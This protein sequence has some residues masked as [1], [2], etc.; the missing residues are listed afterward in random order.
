MIHIYDTPDDLAEAAAGMIAQQARNAIQ[1]SGRFSIVLSG[2]S[3]PEETYARLAR[4]PYQES[5]DWPRTHVFWGDE[6]CVPPDDPRNNARMAYQQ[7]LQ[8]VPL[9]P[10]HIHPIA[11]SL[12]P[13]V[14]ARQYEDELKAFFKNSPPSFDLV[15]LGLG[16]N[17]HTASLFPGTP[18][19][20]ESNAWAAEVYVAEQN[21]WRVTLTTS[22]LNQAAVVIFL[23]QGTSKALVV[24]QVLQG[25]KNPEELPAQ[26]IHPV[27]G[28][29]HW[30]L[31]S[32][33][34][35]MINQPA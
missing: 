7:L 31:D 23:V 24:R 22:L 9:S 10:E 4:N 6:R 29:I 27:S 14:A 35:S 21:L 33:A 11:S 15:L 28:E 16:K 17:G 2:G 3:T 20:K 13:I 26:L 8:H 34:A 19:L 25:P 5:I 18:V 32:Q 30:L 1:K 12:P